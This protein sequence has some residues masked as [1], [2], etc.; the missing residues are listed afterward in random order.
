MIDMTT[1]GLTRAVRSPWTLSFALAAFVAWAPAAAEDRAVTKSWAV[2][3][4]GE[5]LYDE[6]M[7]H[8]PYANPDAPK[9]GKVVLGA[10]G[11]FDTLNPI[12]LKGDFPASIGHTGSSSP[13]STSVGQRTPERASRRSNVLIS[14]AAKCRPTS[15]RVR[16]RSAA[17]R[18]SALGCRRM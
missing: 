18:S 4:F 14:P 17:S 3:E 2:A 6:T 13:P 16:T 1:A 12:I 7:A 5:P 10:F 9:G 15:E 11:T 8:W